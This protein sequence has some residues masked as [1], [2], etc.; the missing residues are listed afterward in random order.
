MSEKCCTFAPAFVKRSENSRRKEII[1][2]TPRIFGFPKNREVAQLVAHYV[3]DV[4][5]GRSS[6]LFSTK[7]RWLRPAYFRRDRSC[8]P[9]FTKK[10]QDFSWPFF[11]SRRGCAPLAPIQRST[12]VLGRG[13]AGRGRRCREPCNRFRRGGR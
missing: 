3:R 1:F 11:V 13:R 12:I 10:G 8:G 2:G 9:D 7:I 5:V 4:G 6:R